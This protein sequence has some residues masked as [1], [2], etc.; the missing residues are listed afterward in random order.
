MRA[1]PLCVKSSGS[2]PISS[3]E[4]EQIS[5]SALR[6]RA[7]RLGRASTRCGSCCA[8][9]AENTATLS[10]PSSCASEAHSGSHVN[11]FSANAGHASAAASMPKKSLSPV[12]MFASERVRAM[13][14]QADDVLQEDLVVRLVHARVV[15][16]VLQADAAELAWAPV[17]HEAVL[18]RL[19][20]RQDR[21]GRRRQAGSGGVDVYAA[22][23][24]LVVAVARAPQRHELIHGLRVPARLAR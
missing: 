9:V 10:P 8:V 6:K 24:E 18:L 13:R 2:Q 12:F 5:T 4:P 19:V 14:A 1:L 20:G 3:C 16:R 15:A 11:T 17:D 21:K 23:V 7:I 22:R